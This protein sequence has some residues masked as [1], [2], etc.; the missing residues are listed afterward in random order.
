MTE[1]EY[2]YQAAGR[3][4]VVPELHLNTLPDGTVVILEEETK[5]IHRAIANEICGSPESLSVDELDFLCDI[6]GT[7]YSGIADYLGLHRSTLTKWRTAGRVPRQITGLM[8]KKWFWFKLFGDQ[9]GKGTLQI[10][11]MQDE[12]SLLSAVR[13]RAIESDLAEPM[14]LMKA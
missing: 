14:E 13:S 7:P 1:R 6:T 12:T 3:T 9:L 4:W 8:L 2:P 10:E 5:R 11:D